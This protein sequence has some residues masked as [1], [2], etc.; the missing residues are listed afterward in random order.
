M[1]QELAEQMGYKDF[2]EAGQDI[3]WLYGKDVK[4][5]RKDGKIVA[6]RMQPKTQTEENTDV[7]KDNTTKI[8]ES[9]EK[10]SEN[11]EKIQ[12]N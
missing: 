2:N 10:V 5:E 11:I 4:Y 9:I 8:R 7:I 1:K 6:K 3:S 12:C